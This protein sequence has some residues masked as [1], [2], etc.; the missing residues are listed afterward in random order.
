[1]QI[2][3]YFYEKKSSIFHADEEGILSRLFSIKLNT[4]E[5]DGIMVGIGKIYSIVSGRYP[6]YVINSRLLSAFK[7][8]KRAL[9][10]PVAKITDLRLLTV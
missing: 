2:I 5:T 9:V 3:H 8:F 1:M 4:S 6:R 10:M 7:L